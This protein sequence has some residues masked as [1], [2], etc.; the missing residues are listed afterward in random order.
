LSRSP[1]DARPVGGASRILPLTDPDGNRVVF[2][3]A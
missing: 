3:G 2:T 1:T